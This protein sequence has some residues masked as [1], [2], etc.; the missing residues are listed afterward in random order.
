MSH[1][2]K[3]ELRTRVAVETIWNDRIIRFFT[4]PPRNKRVPKGRIGNSPA[5]YCRVRGKQRLS[6]EGTAEMLST[7]MAVAA[8]ILFHLISSPSYNQREERV[9]ERRPPYSTGGS[10]M[11]FLTP[12]FLVGGLAIGAPIL[13]HLIR[14]SVRE[15]VEFSSLMFLNP[16]PPKTTRKRK[17]EHLL[18]LALRCLILLALAAGFARP[19]F[20]KDVTP[21]NATGARR[22]IILLLRHV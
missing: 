21:P 18:L 4:I 17:L 2:Q 16:S 15:R 6:P 11:N 9:G 14:R 7:A 1:S 3:L 22:Q 20:A 10:R 19:F 12:L 13:F 5:V 8:P